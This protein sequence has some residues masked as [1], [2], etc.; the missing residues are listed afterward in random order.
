[1]DYDLELI[2]LSGM[3]V[4]VEG[5]IIKP[6]TLRE[7]VQMGYAQYL[8]YLGIFLLC[9]DDIF[10]DEI[11]PKFQ[12]LKPF[13]ILLNSGPTSLFEEFIASIRFMTR[14]ESVEYDL[15]TQLV[16]VG[17]GVIDRNNWD[18]I[19][20]IVQWANYIKSNPREEYHPAN[21]EAAE[22]IKKVKRLKKKKP[23]KKEISNLASIVSGLV[24]KSSNINLLNVWD[25]TMY[26]LFDGLHRHQLIDNYHHLLTGIYSGSIDPKNINVEQEHWAK[27]IKS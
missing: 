18:S 3:P 13:D 24:W 5:I 7:I 12:E 6:Y 11:P 8:K 15:R 25:L 22:F 23:P 4:I 27:I 9:L 21:Q 1:M 14:M 26:Q 19:C 17:D 16:Y 10:E 2:L 20:Q